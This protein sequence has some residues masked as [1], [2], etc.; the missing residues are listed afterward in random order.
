AAGGQQVP[1]TGG[2]GHGQGP[3]LY[4]RKTA[5]N[6]RKVNY[7]HVKVSE[8]YPGSLERRVDEQQ[9]TDGWLKKSV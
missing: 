9:T 1:Q 6:P 5:A 2:K 8:L 7:E 3:Q 4:N